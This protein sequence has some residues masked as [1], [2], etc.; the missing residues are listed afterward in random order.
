MHR[1]LA[2]A[3]ISLLAI[4]LA[5]PQPVSAQN[6]PLP[7]DG[8]CEDFYDTPDDCEE[9]TGVSVCHGWAEVIGDH[10][11]GNDGHDTCGGGA[12]IAAENCGYT[13]Y[14]CS[15]PFGADEAFTALAAGDLRSLSATLVKAPNLSL[16]VNRARGLI[17]IESR[18]ARYPDG[19]IVAQVPI[20]D[21]RRPKVANLGG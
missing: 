7:C 3:A 16:R 13:H 10:N 4:V 12:C 14:W 1:T 5:H 9:V 6:P 17:Q 8:H 2:V 21:Y 19:A 20:Q 15:Y 18:C 11:R